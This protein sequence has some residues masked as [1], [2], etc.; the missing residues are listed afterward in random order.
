MK[1]LLLLVSTLL[2]C[3]ASCEKVETDLPQIGDG[4]TENGE[5]V[6]RFTF[7][8]KGDFTTNFEDMT[9]SAVRIEN[10][11]KAGI[12]DIWVLDYVNGVCVQSVHQGSTQSDI[13]FG[14][15]PMSLTYG[16]HDIKF[17]ASKGEGASL[18]ESAISWTKIKDTF[19]LDYPVDVVAS[20]NGNRAPELARAISGLKITI[21]DEIPAEA[22]TM[23]VTLGSRSQ[24]ITLPTLSA[25]PYTESTVDLD[26]TSL[27]GKTNA[28]V[29]CYTLAGDEEW[30]STASLAVK[31]AD[32]TVITS[33]D[34]PDVQLKRNRMT[35]ITGEVFNRTNGFHVAIDSEWDAD[36]P[37][38]F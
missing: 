3:L 17:I 14:S 15:V 11:N 29:I 35:V 26:V 30:T 24:T 5:A 7:H 20:S 1:K 34:L 16:H 8:V 4:V 9:R 27:V 36:Y 2:L 32:G 37:M 18:T 13:T 21:T 31:R 38:T 19:T 23:C 33:L 28:S 10:E 6:K 22:K 25:L 12:T